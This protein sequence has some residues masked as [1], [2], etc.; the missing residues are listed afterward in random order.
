[1]LAG[2]VPLKPT[3]LQGHPADQEAVCP[4]NPVIIIQA[5]LKIHA[6]YALEL[7]YALYF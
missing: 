1:M 5:V 6:L 3:K 2:T 4:C 7:L